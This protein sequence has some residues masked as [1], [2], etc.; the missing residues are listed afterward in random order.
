M[1]SCLNFSCATDV[2]VTAEKYKGTKM[3]L[4]KF[5]KIMKRVNDIFKELNCVRN[6]WIH[7]Q[8]SKNKCSILK[9]VD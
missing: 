9:H 4:R 2:L 1:I 8:F 6:V 5:H 3:N 7:F